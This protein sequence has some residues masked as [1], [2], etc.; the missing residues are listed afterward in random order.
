MLGDKDEFIS[1][2]CTDYISKPFDIDNLDKLI[3][4]YIQQNK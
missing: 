3:E 2:G 1:G 4:K